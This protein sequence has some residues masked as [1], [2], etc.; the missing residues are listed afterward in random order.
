MDARPPRSII[1]VSHTHWDR[2]WYHPLGVM[3]TRLAA[4]IDALLDAPDGLPFL[5]DGQAIVLD[6]YLAMRPERREA[7]REALRTRQLEAGPWYVLADMLIPS[8]EALVRNLSL[9]MRTVRDAGGD[10]PAVLYSPDAF[11]HAAAGP[12]LADGF[13][14]DVAIV[15]R[16]Y[17]GPSYPSSAVAQWTHPSGASVLLYHLPTGGYEVGSS[18]PTTAAGARQWWRDARESIVARNTLDVALLPNG[19]DHHARQRDRLHAIELL[20]D[21]AL[22][23]E[24][25]ARSLGYFAMLLHDAASVHVLKAVQGELRDSSGWTWSLQGTFATRAHQKRMNAQV[26]RLLVREA[27]PWAA[28][29]WFTS[30]WRGSTLRSA[31]TTLLGAH[32]HDTL[33]G[34]SVD[35]VAQAADQRWAEARQHG[36]AVRDAA[37][38]RLLG[39]DA[40]SQRDLEAEWRPTVVLRNPAARARGGA[41]ML[42]LLDH[43]AADPVG[44]GSAARSGARIAPPAA[45]P[46]W[47][48]DD[49]L[50]LL[51]RSRAFDRVES[52]QHY[53]RNAVVRVS[54]VMAWID[55]IGGYALQSVPLAS[56]GSVVQPVPGALRVRGTDAELT[57][58]HWRL[59][60][61]EHGATAVHAASGARLESL[62]W[63]ESTTDAGDTY[64]PSLRGE[65]IRALWSAPRLQTRG[66]LRASWEL[67]TALARPRFST[68]PA[69][70]PT[71]R[72]LPPREPVTI[73]AVATVSI[74]AGADRIDIH[75]RGENVA[76]DHRL[77]WVLP[78]P[79]GTHVLQHTADAGFGAVVRTHDARDPREWSAEQRLP[80]APL[81]RWLWFTGDTHGFGVISDGLAE[82]EVQPDGHL[83]ITL[84]RAVG[85]LSR[86]DLPERPGH[87]GW[88]LAT[89]LAQSLGPFEARFA[90][91][92]LSQDADV[93]LQQL[94]HTADDVL[95]PVHGDTWRGVAVPHTPFKGITL[96][97]D[98]LTCS[99]IRHSDD[100]EWLVLR[101]VNQRATPLRGRWNLPRAATEAHLARLDETPLESLA[102]ADSSVHFEAAP[103]AIVTLLVR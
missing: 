36:G 98:G 83:A 27:E 3:R 9:G 46:E 40:A 100:G 54:E 80:T 21:A 50:Q 6:D 103:H 31:W 35:E 47:S 74:D 15:W 63:L 61:T 5:L 55:P 52:P 10:P 81:H 89:P 91:I 76:G 4:L 93:A 88:P 19:A 12:V 24:I 25:E 84:L 82:Y 90:L 72:A 69:V 33:C 85:E 53:P 8:G 99:A 28:L 49:L 38:E 97:G 65:T 7:L 60:S 20:A 86:R 56:L 1:V 57:G 26:E 18:L 79:A 45:A 67:T 64:T 39:H 23:D 58:P 34:C 42:R 37:I 95:L 2:E 16:G 78:L 62:G 41:V 73:P 13:G 101:C 71:G 66:P 43:A 51:H 14:L 30:G 102:C 44:P 59:R 96:E 68:A 22:P 75:L 87:A 77:R 92:V 94:E 17:G 11:G 32:P 70:E 48:G 29:A